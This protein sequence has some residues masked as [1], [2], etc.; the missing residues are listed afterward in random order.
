MGQNGVL[1]S[2]RETELMFHS[3]YLAVSEIQTRVWDGTEPLGCALG[4]QS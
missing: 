4:F 2:F 1:E 3:V